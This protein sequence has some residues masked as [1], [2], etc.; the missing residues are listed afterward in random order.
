[1]VQEIVVKNT[2]CRKIS[3]GLIT[4]DLTHFDLLSSLQS[5]KYKSK[6]EDGCTDWNPRRETFPY[7]AFRL[8]QTAFGRFGYVVKKKNVFI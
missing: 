5:N 3:N 8:M 2:S 7:V 6:E 1:M 4:F